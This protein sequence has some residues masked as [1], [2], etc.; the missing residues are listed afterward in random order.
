MPASC[1]SPRE[2]RTCRTN[3]PSPWAQR[4]RRAPAAASKPEAPA[5]APG[6]ANDNIRTCLDPQQLLPPLPPPPRRSPTGRKTRRRRQCRRPWPR[7]PRQ[8]PVGAV[9]ARRHG[10][11]SPRP[12]S[13]ALVSA[14]PTHC[15]TG[16]LLLMHAAKRPAH[17][18]ML[19]LISA[20]VTDPMDHPRI[21]AA[22]A[23]VAGMVQRLL[24]AVAMA[25]VADCCCHGS[26]AHCL[27]RTAVAVAWLLAAC[28]P[29]RSGLV[30]A[31][32]VFIVY[33]QQVSGPVRSSSRLRRTL[34]FCCTPL[35][36]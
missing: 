1:P 34:S 14:P 22:A 28:P 29:T 6:S 31:M 23:G 33:S 25:T 7:R 24:A 3:R 17:T 26:V 13:G 15:H 8:Q 20:S 36:L 16:M 12:R 35:S 4:P 10:R 2:R 18:G 11:S 21:T 5:P 32:N 27:V 9:Q 30:F 19:L